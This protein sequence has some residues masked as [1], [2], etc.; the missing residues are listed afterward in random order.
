M[1]FQVVF[2]GL[3]KVFPGPEK[4]RPGKRS[5]TNYF[6]I[7]SGRV[8]SSL[9]KVFQAWKNAPPLI[10]MSLF[11][12]SITAQ[13]RQ[14]ISGRGTFELAVERFSRPGKTFFQARKTLDH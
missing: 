11:H 14:I 4:S 10:Q 5:T 2:P 6:E 7:I 1:F 3:E 13:A 12:L 8:F 9:E